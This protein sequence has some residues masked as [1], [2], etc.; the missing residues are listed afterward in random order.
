MKLLILFLL[1]FVLAAC[2]TMPQTEW[3]QPGV[4]D[5]PAVYNG[6]LGG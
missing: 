1:S 3:K 4:L 5:C 6:C 2:T